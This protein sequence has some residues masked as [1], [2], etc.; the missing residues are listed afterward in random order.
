MIDSWLYNRH[1]K[2]LV[3][4][5]PSRT[6]M[7][8][9]LHHQFSSVLTHWRRRCTVKLAPATAF[10]VPTPELHAGWY[11]LLLTLTEQIFLAAC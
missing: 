1:G 2:Y 4:A 8:W 5:V 6:I 3:L 9:Q 7:L 10:P 11:R